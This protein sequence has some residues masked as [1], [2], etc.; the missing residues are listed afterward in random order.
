MS[1]S[2]T[3]C[4]KAGSIQYI[5]EIKRKY[6]YSIESTIYDILITAGWKLPYILA[7][8]SS[9]QFMV[10]KDQLKFVQRKKSLE[11]IMLNV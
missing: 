3:F 9:P 10:F 8:I 11:N 5:D 6:L 2:V 7:T 4:G 1:H